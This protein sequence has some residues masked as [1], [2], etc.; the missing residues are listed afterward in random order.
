MVTWRAFFPNP[1]LSADDLAGG[2]LVAT[3]R[4]VGRVE[5]KRKATSPGETDQME[6]KMLL[7]LGGVN[8]SPAPKPMICNRT[9][10]RTIGGLF[11]D[12]VQGWTGQQITIHAP[13]V[14]AFGKIAPAL[15]VR[16]QQ[17]AAPPGVTATR[18]AVQP[19]PARTRKARR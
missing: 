16:I 14:E 5:L 9:N 2:D 10:A 3:I 4:S 12:D 11:G 1:Y 15:R 6:Q 17:I 19:R 7:Q 13:M 18:Q 8:G